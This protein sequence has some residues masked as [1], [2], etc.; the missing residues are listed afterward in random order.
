MEYLFGTSQ[1]YRPLHVTY[2]DQWSECPTLLE[3][4]QDSSFSSG[5]IDIY[6][7]PLRQ[8]EAGLQE[9]PLSVSPSAPYLLNPLI[10]FHETSF[11]CSS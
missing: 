7:I 4:S 8:A 9:C 5:F 6:L 11:I 3:I 2:C 10:D 1:V